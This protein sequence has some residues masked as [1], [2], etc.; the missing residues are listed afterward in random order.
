MLTCRNRARFISTGL[1]LRP[2]VSSAFKLSEQA[3]KAERRRVLLDLSRQV[4][5]I[6]LVNVVP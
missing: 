1:L 5:H 4:N 6:I 3:R 2:S